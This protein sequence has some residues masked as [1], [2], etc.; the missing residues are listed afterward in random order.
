MT[1]KV[2]SKLF[3]VVGVVFTWAMPPAGNVYQTPLFEIASTLEDPNLSSRVVE[4][5]QDGANLSRLE[6]IE[7]LNDGHE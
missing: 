6:R 5:I 4:M 3:P 1:I 2:I 7:K